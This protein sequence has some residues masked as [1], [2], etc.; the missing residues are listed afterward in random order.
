MSGSV[1]KTRRYRIW[2]SGLR[3]GAGFQSSSLGSCQCS[4]GSSFGQAR[5]SGGLLCAVSVLLE[6][7]RESLPHAKSSG[8][9]RPEGDSTA[10]RLL[11]D[12]SGCNPPLRARSRRETGSRDRQERRPLRYLRMTKLQ[13]RTRRRMC[14]PPSECENSFVIARHS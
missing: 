9:S 1:S 13:F 6:T 4:S 8:Q 12:V 14:R 7:K 10:P 11:R 5:P 3:V 2:V